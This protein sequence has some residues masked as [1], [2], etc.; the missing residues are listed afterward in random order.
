MDEDNKIFEELLEQRK[1]R[2]SLVTSVAP[3]GY[4][5]SLVS[6]G[7]QGIEPINLDFA[8]LYPRTMT[9]RFP[10][11]NTIRKKKIRNM[12]PDIE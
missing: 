1:N 10:S 5:G 11:K 8:S 3:Q 12:F 6:G 2:K 7:F 4:A 9:M